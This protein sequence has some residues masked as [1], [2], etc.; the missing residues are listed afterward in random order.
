MALEIASKPRGELYCASIW[1]SSS[2]HCGLDYL[3]HRQ[4]LVVYPAQDYGLPVMPMLVNPIIGQVVLASA[5]STSSATTTTT[6]EQ[7]EQ[8]DK[9]PFY[10]M[11]QLPK[12]TTWKKKRMLQ[13]QFHGGQL[14]CF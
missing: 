14:L 1:D 9:P 2:C 12:H 3:V 6:P 8:D 13:I 7:Q 10:E 11:Y 4:S 5:T